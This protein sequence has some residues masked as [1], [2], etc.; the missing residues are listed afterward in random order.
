MALRE[1]AEPQGRTSNV[2]SAEDADYDKAAE[3]WHNQLALLD[4]PR[5]YESEELLS[6]SLYQVEDAYFVLDSNHRVLVAHYHGF[7]VID[8]EVR[9]LRSLP[10]AE[11][12]HPDT[13]E[14]TQEV[15][16]P[17]EPTERRL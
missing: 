12:P 15:V 11:P 10:P 3:H 1:R 16:C 13:I 5:A 2:A 9:K 14:M 8:A 17:D 4:Y 6:V 7:E